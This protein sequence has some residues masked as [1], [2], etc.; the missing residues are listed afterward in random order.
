[1]VPS[2]RLLLA[3]CHVG[4]DKSFLR[5]NQKFCEIVGYTQDDL[6][7]MKVDE[8]TPVEDR[9]REYQLVSGLFKELRPT[10][11]F[12]KRCIRKDQTMVWVNLT[13]SFVSNIQGGAKFFIGVIEDIT[14]RKELEAELRQA[15][16]IDVV[17]LLAG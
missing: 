4:S 12:E 10:C 6:R 15:Q 17:G 9:E 3:F 2:N 7:D 13:V 14:A 11:S 8:L 5:V 16:N 1:M